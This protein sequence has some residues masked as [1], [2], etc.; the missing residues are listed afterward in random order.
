M[1][2]IEEEGSD[3]KMQKWI[4]VFVVTL[5]SSL[6]LSGCVGQEETAPKIVGTARHFAISEPVIKP[7]RNRGPFDSTIANS[8]YPP[9]RFEKSWRGIIIHHSATKEGNAAVFNNYHKNGHKW[10]GIGYNFVIGNGNGSGDGQ[11]EVTFRWRDQV[12]GAHTGGTPN[13]WAN[14]DGIG[15]CLVGDFSKTRPTDRQMRSLVKLIRFLQK[16][17]KIPASRIYGHKGTPGYKNGTGCP[18]KFS[19]ARLKRML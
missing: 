13:N 18:G 3:K 6:L 15:I 2:S 16:R 17:Y 7:V 12:A 5:I 10:K 11:V 9:K 19:M 4:S 14:V 1:V 8:W